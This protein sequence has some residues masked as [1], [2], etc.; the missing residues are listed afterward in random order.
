MC[1]LS[2]TREPKNGRKHKLPTL[3]PQLREQEEQ[4]IIQGLQTVPQS[5]SCEIHPKHPAEQLSLFS[6]SLERS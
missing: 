5:G 4:D 6:T 1:P 3:T 2:L